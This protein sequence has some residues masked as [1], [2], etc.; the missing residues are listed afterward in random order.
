M[1]HAT[2]VR[3]CVRA[4]DGC[5]YGMRRIGKKIDSALAHAHVSAGPHSESATLK[6]MLGSL[7]A[8]AAVA[9]DSGAPTSASD[10]TSPMRPNPSSVG[11][12]IIRPDSTPLVVG[13]HLHVD[14]RATDAAGVPI[15]AGNAEI[16]STN[17]S[18]APLLGAV[19]FP[20]TLPPDPVLYALSATFDLA[21]PG[22][23]AIRARLGILSDSVVIAVTAAPPAGSAAAR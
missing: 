20:I 17:P 16:T 8:A 4:H 21:S 3:L 7:I 18:V 9:C 1:H 2:R 12:L 11:R 23:T 6:W 5:I 13:R 22:S 19:A 10:A 15:D 14:I